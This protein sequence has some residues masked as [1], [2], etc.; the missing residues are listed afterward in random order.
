ME[1]KLR[2]ALSATVLA[3][4]SANPLDAGR[5]GCIRGPDGEDYCGTESLTGNASGGSGNG[6]GANGGAPTASKC[7][8]ACRSLGAC[9]DLSTTG[10]EDEEGCVRACDSDPTGS[11]C[12][13]DAKGNCDAV[14]ACLTGG[15]AG[16]TAI[17]RPACEHLS[18]CYDL[19]EAGLDGLEGC[20]DYCEPDPQG[21]E[22]VANA[23]S[24]ETVAACVQA[25]AGG[26]GGGGGGGGG[27]TLCQT[28]CAYL[29]RCID[30]SQTEL[31]NVEGCVSACEADNTGAQ[32][33]ANTGGDCGAVS[34]CFQ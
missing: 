2:V 22:C 12:L 6:G 31:G 26:N 7:R 27:A 17:C 24:C 18:Q 3:A 34:A 32:C 1:M 15:G 25:I 11:A 14:N 20:V 29:S 8:D 33:V 4:C 16:D 19:S 23:Q 10:L 30:L 21:F 9:L 13:A 5:V 28:A